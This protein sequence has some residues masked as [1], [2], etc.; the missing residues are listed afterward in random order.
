MSGDHPGRIFISYSRKDGAAFARDLRATLEKENLSFW[1]DL[2]KLEGGQDWWSQIENALRS[3]ELQHFILVVTP[4]ALESGVVRQ[5]IRLARQEGKSV[6]PVR[7][8]GVLDL[9]K[10]P[11]WLGHVYDL[12]L[13]EQRTALV[14]KLQREAE[15]R[16]V[17]MMAPELPADFVPR[18]KEFD[19]LKARLLD[20]K[21]DSIAGITAALRGAG[22]YGKTTLARALARDPDIQ[23]AF[24]DGIL[25]AE[26]GEKPDPSA[27]SRPSPTSSP[28]SRAN[29]RS[30]RRSM[31]PRR[32]SLRP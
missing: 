2:I 13:P 15:P 1:Q 31:R 12:D 10:L 21:G 3:R 4:N 9:N 32:S 19:A 18:P 7:G 28:S 30:S 24:F 8:P 11:R 20:P 14:G 23:D 25:W 22:G 27:W 6:C 26:L 5:E 29:G 17:P 16:R